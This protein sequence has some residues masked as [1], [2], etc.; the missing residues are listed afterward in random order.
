M[1]I[2][3]TWTIPVKVE[4]RIGEPIAF[5]A[6][7]KAR[8]VGMLEFDE[9]V[10]EVQISEMGKVRLN[11]PDGLVAAFDLTPAI[12]TIAANLHLAAEPGEPEE[13]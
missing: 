5:S 11:H 12:K 10:I 4:T 13:L 7:A 8:T 1:T 2:P 9:T 3:I 6:L